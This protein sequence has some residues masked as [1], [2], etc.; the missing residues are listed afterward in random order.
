MM[1]LQKDVPRTLELRFAALV[2][3]LAAVLLW[4][5]EADRL[6]LLNDEGIYLDGALRI[7][8][9]EVPYRDFF[10][11]T[12][13][14]SFWLLAGVFQLLGITLSLARLIPIF[15][16]AFITASVYWLAAHLTSRGF[17][18]AL[19]FIFFSFQFTDSVPLN[20]NHRLDSSALAMAAL[21]CTFHGIGFPCWRIFFVAGAFAAAA[22]WVTPSIAIVGMLL[23]TW[24]LWNNDLRRQFPAYLAG[25]LFCSAMATG[26]LLLQG[27]LWPMVQHMF[28]AGANYSSANR[29]SYG[30]IIGGYHAIFREVGGLEIFLR[31]SIIFCFA[32]PAI[33]PIGVYLGSLFGTFRSRQ[34]LLLLFVSVGFLLSAYP[35]MDVVHLRSSAPI[36]YVLAGCLYHRTLGRFLRP[37]VSLGF[38]LL[39]A[40]LFLCIA[41]S[42]VSQNFVVETR[43]GQVRVGSDDLTLVRRLSQYVQPG[44]SLFVFPYLPV[45]YFLTGGKNPT[46][47]SFLQPGMMSQ[48]DEEAALTELQA[49]SPQWVLYSD[50]PKE[51]YLR[52]WPSSD[53]KRLHMPSIEEFIRSRYHLVERINLS[54]GEFRILRLGCDRLKD[55]SS[56]TNRPKTLS[57]RALENLQNLAPRTRL[58]AYGVSMRK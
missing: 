57:P 54:N 51:A 47:Y 1:Y 52:I 46:H 55:N 24:I 2:F 43:V 35:R 41:I 38:W 5:I 23:A 49:N 19:A 10:V 26:A 36:F 28:W 30:S 44:E 31:G 7:L 17:A 21:V 34:E 25:L 18:A 53:P 6:V 29:M 14:G 20:V 15:D 4:L 37:T 3:I 11:L 50:V 56:S 32:L 27:A 40:A 33:L 13:P 12:G 22:A 48:A 39:P 58:T 45:A 9:G 42:R 8:N 16:L